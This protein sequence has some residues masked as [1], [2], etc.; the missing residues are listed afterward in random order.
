MTAL[1]I[2]CVDYASE[3][4]SHSQAMVTPNAFAS[5][6]NSASQTCRWFFSIREMI[7]GVISIPS[8]FISRASPL[9]A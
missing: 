2:S 7:S 4:S 6:F 5:I 9:A 3:S 8:R 1:L